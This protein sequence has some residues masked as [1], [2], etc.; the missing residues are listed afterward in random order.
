MK[1]LVPHELGFKREMVSLEDILSSP[2]QEEKTTTHFK[3]LLNPKRERKRQKTKSI[4]TTTRT[5]TKTQ[6]H[7][8]KDT[9]SYKMKLHY[10]TMKIQHTLSKNKI[11]ELA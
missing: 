4:K 6:L 7:F 5:T 11:K 2:L 1:Q 10:T 8:T 3:V 9:N